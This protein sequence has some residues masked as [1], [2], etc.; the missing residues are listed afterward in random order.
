[1][2]HACNSLPNL[3]FSDPFTQLEQ[4][5]R[6]REREAEETRQAKENIFSQKV[7]EREQKLRDRADK[8][9]AEEKEN[10]N[11]V[12]AKRAQLEQ[13]MQEMAELRRPT[14]ASDSGSSI[15]RGSPTEKTK[16]KGMSLFR[17]NN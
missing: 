11:I 15:G 8:L 4:E 9:D 14:G 6:E 1:M 16:K 3:R 10:E 17:S 7:A 5:Q 2:Q 13:L 12:N